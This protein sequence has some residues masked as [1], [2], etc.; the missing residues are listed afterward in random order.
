LNARGELTKDIMPDLLHPNTLGYVKW[1]EAVE[2]T[3]ASLL[4][5]AP[6][7]A[8][9]L[10]DRNIERFQQQSARMEQGNVDLLF[11][12]DSI[13]HGWEGAGKD[14]WEKYYGNRNA[15]NF[16]IGGDRTGHVLWRLANSPLDKISPKMA[17]VMIGTNN[18]GHNS[19][20]PEQ[21]VQGIWQIVDR[22]KVQYPEMKILLLEVFPR[23]STPDDNYRQQVNK[24]NEGL[25][26]IFVNVENVQLLGLENLYLDENGVLP[27]SLMP[28]MLHPN[29]EGYEIWANAI[30]PMVKEALGETK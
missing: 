16:G 2:P 8:V 25:R 13:T 22:L 3:I 29:A 23:G 7:M 9:T 28:D 6:N 21:T 10:E 27:V 1:A 30:E 18:I 12:G 20:S 24:I 17:V 19:S 26:K 11:V 5:E 14:V 15:M 4:N